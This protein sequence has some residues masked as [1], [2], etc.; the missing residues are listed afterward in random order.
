[1]DDIS[2]ESLP[3]RPGQ[4]VDSTGVRS[5]DP[6]EWTQMAEVEGSEDLDQHDYASQ[7]SAAAIE[8][9]S[10]APAASS[11]GAGR[12]ELLMALDSVSGES[13]GDE[14]V[15]M[16]DAPG[17]DSPDL[18]GSEEDE[19]FSE[20]PAEDEL[21]RVVGALLL[22]S[23]E[24][25]S[26]LRLAQSTNTT[27]KQVRVALTSL[28]ESLQTAGLAL[29]VSVNGDLVRLL[30]TPDV[31]DYLRNLRTVKKRE[32]LSAAGLETL[33]VIAYRQP[34]MRAEIEAIRGVKAGPILRTLLDH[35]M[36]KMVGRANVPGRPLQ[37][38]TTQHFLETFGLESL[39]DLP[40][41]KE[42]RQL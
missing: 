35:R 25:L 24:S 3:D 41:V 31:F 17:A 27:P 21:S 40:S 38:G 14:D 37:Y 8:A 32:K 33:A 39:A 42:F 20:S 28:S 18:A 23:R 26:L 11:D 13:S 29:E 2:R 10:Q 12:E 30:T 9:R 6:A 34:V 1:M 15:P 22:S 4:R 36:V 19:E 5:K 7:Q 16:E